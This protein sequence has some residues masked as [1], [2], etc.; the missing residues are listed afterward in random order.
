M[1]ETQENFSRIGSLLTLSAQ[2]RQRA[3][4]AL[5]SLP[6]ETAQQVLYDWHFWARDNQLAPKW[7]WRKWL[8]LAGRGYGKTRSGAEWIGKCVDQGRAH[9]IAL[10]SKTPASARDEMIE[11][12]SG[13]LNIS[14]PWRYPKYEPSKRRLTWPNGAVALIASSW[15]PDILRGPQFDTAWCDEVGAWKYVRETYDNLMLGLRL[16]DDPRC[17]ITTTPKPIQLL[18]E[19][20]DDP[21]T[22]VTRGS[23]YENRANLAGA[24]FDE[25]VARYEGTRTGRQ[26]I[27]AELLDEA[28]DA[29]WKRDWFDT[30]RCIEAPELNRVVVAIDPAVTNTEESNETGIICCGTSKERHGYVL[31]DLSGRY[32]PK[33]WAEAAITLFKRH[34]ADRL[35]AEVNNGGDMVESTLRNVWPGVPYEAVHATRGKVIR[36]EPVATVYEQRRIHHV[37]RFDELEDQLVQWEPGMPS[38]DRLDALVWGFTALAKHLITGS[39]I[40]LHVG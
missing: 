2:D 5:R 19:L 10:V 32:S 27:Y 7:S 16:G 29:L 6:L 18:R 33:G 1:V 20:L 22:A 8:I 40:G 37:G 3:L 17:V 13:F 11:G 24:F 23:T 36:A 4:T 15:E 9:R 34:S 21:T 28:E 30:H 39:R 14:P 35:V 12:E 31:G 26:E 38:P 25:V